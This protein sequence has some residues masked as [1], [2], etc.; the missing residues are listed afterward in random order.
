MR[1][2]PFNKIKSIL[3]ELYCEGMDWI[4]L[5]EDTVQYGGGPNTTYK[6]NLKN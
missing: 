4:Q 5:P 2:S 1:C 6:L 3:Q